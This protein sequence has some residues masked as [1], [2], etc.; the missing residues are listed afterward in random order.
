M[1]YDRLE[2]PRVVINSQQA[3]R[4]PQD[5]ESAARWPMLIYNMCSSIQ[6]KQDHRFWTLKPINYK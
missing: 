5:G 6:I 3:P 4:E 1:S 2:Y